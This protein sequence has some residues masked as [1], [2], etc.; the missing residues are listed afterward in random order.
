MKQNPYLDLNYVDRT[1]QVEAEFTPILE[2]IQIDPQFYAELINDLMF[3][4]VYGTRE[5]ALMITAKK[6]LLKR[7]QTNQ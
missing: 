2:E 1:D 7:H 6:N 4:W 3:H 5:T